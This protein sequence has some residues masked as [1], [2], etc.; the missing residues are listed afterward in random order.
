MRNNIH[1]TVLAC[2]LPL[3]AKWVWHVC[4]AKKFLTTG[5][6]VHPSDRWFSWPLQRLDSA[7]SKPVKGKQTS[8][9]PVYSKP[10]IL[11][12]IIRYLKKH[13]VT[14]GAWASRPVKSGKWSRLSVHN[15]RPVYHPQL[16]HSIT[17]SGTL[18]NVV[19]QPWR[20]RWSCC[21]GVVDQI[22]ACHIWSKQSLVDPIASSPRLLIRFPSSSASCGI[23]SIKRRDS[24][25]PAG[26]GS[27]SNVFSMWRGVK[28][29][30]SLGEKHYTCLSEQAGGRVTTGFKR[31]GFDISRVN[32]GTRLSSAFRLIQVMLDRTRI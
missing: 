11:Y 32:V 24:A 8:Q 7:P 19:S 12:L 6:H 18:S 27:L 1:L 9:T 10:R 29:G 3:P 28:R 17:S 26:P 16:M 21:A 30:V 25:P 22:F 4:Y 13:E 2:D 23:S 14:R 20:L 5:I 31:K 15:R